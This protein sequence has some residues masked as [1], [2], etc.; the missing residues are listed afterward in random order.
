MK[1]V[2]RSQHEQKVANYYRLHSKIYDATRWSFLFGRE[3]LLGHIPDLPPN[4]RIL[5]VGCGTGKNIELLQYLFP[6]GDIYGVDLSKDMLSKARQKTKATGRVKLM[7]KQYGS[8]KIS[9]KSFDLILLS[10]TLTMMGDQAEV[11][12]QQL[13]EDLS[14]K[15]YVAVVDFHNTQ[16]KWFKKWM[17]RNHVVMNGHLLPLLNKYFTAVK[18]SV[19]RA[20]FGLW[21]YFMFIGHQ[22]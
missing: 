6:D 5:E 3:K 8:D 14:S 20:Y 7:N 19:N 10:Y 18:S 1:S 16:F 2:T 17:F 22:G 21:K 9:T 4:P 13:S 15:G 11:I 12:L